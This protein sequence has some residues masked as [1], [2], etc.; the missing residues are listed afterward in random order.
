MG[1]LWK[2]T[3]TKNRQTTLGVQPM[4]CTIVLSKIDKDPNIK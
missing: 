3:D 2:I 1:N 4:E